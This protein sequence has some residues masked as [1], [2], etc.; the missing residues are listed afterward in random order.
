M[1]LQNTSHSVITQKTIMSVTDVSIILRW[2][3]SQLST[4]CIYQTYSTV[5]TVEYN[6]GVMNQSWSQT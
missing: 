2:E 5:A 6:V 3:Q 1:F 4:L